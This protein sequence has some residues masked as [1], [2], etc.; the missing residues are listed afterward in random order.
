MLL[1]QEIA[2]QLST[3]VR[4]IKFSPE[5]IQQIRNLVGRGKSR[6]EIAELI[7]VTLGSLQVT[8]S[9]LGISLRRPVFY[10][11]SGLLQRGGLHSNSGTATPLVAMAVFRFD[12]QKK[13]NFSKI[14]SRVRWSKP[15]PQHPLMSGRIRRSWQTWPS[16]CST[17]AASE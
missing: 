4:Q 2:T 10:T 17:R 5:R 16:G 1:T 3:H 15:K 14:H 7:G 6:E 9:R 13:N 8:C 12:R 11:Q